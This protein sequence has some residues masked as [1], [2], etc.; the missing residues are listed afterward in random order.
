MITKDEYKRL[1]NQK[2]E[3]LSQI[4][5]YREETQA[6]DILQNEEN[7]VGKCFKIDVEYDYTHYKETIYVKVLS[8]IHKSSYDVWSMDFVL[9]MS[10]KF[11]HRL[12]K[13]GADKFD[14]H[15]EDNDIIW[16]EEHP[17][18]DFRQKNCTEITQDEYDQ[19]LYRLNDDIEDFYKK[20]YKIKDIFGE[21]Y[22]KEIKEL[23]QENEVKD[24]P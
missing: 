16:F 8:A 7:L 3:I 12:L 13:I 18:S 19:A 15:F 17:I 10:V 14:Y 23:R 24:L 11:K 1:E 9:P 20:S 21:D 4:N 2:W 6:I 22:E 5:K